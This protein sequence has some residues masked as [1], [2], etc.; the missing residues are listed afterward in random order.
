MSKKKKY[1][2]SGT[3]GG[4]SK[5]KRRGAGSRGGRG[6]S[7]RKHKKVKYSKE[8]IKPRR[9][10][11]KRPSAVVKEKNTIN[12]IELEARLDEF[13]EKG[14]AEKTKNGFNVNLSE[15]GYQKLLGKGKITETL[16]V[17]CEDFSKRAKEKLEKSGGSA[18]ELP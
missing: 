15:A 7:G 18:I 10:G 2:G 6:L 14:Y 17:E 13:I 11:F 9:K 4:G 5:K 8:K 3:H 1:R 16:E 12:I